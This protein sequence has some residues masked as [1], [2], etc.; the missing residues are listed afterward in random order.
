MGL[1]T[2]INPSER[3]SKT[4]SVPFEGY[5]SIFIAWGW[6]SSRFEAPN[7][8]R[9]EHIDLDLEHVFFASASVILSDAGGS[10]LW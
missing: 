10:T 4:P 3:V 2:R 7:S 1:L 5:P 9:L 6:T 8:G